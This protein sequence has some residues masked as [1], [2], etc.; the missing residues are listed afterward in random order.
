MVGTQ[1]NTKLDLVREY[2]EIPVATEDVKKTTITTPFGLF[3][4]LRT[5]FDLR[6]DSQT[7]QHMMDAIFRDMPNVNCYMDDI[8]VAFDDVTSHRDSILPV[9]HRLRENGLVLKPE[10][11]LLVSRG[12]N[13]HEGTRR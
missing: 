3:E 10:N 6:N 13:S 4:F 7:S 8:L 12:H 5:P 1:L 2:H 9:F 11:V